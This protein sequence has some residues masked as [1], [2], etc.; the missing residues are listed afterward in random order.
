MFLSLPDITIVPGAGCGQLKQLISILIATSDRFLVVLDKDEEGHTA[1]KNYNAAFGELFTRNVF[2]YSFS[3]AKKFVLESLLDPED[4]KRIKEA[5]NCKS[6]K[7]AFIKLYY[8][9]RNQ[10]EVIENQM[11]DASLANLKRL[12]DVILAHFS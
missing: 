11:E 2:Q 3:N 6:I 4:I 9:S 8:S 7:K 5:T 10:I 1:F 12:E